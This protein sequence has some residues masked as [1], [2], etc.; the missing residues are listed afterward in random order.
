[1]KKYLFSLAAALSIFASSC[2]GD[3]GWTVEGNIAGADGQKMVVEGFNNGSWYTLDTL[4][5]KNGG[6]FEYTSPA[7]SP[8]PDIYRLNLD[9]KMIYFP[10][11]SIETVTVNGNAKSFDRDF[12][13]S[14]SELAT[15]L[16]NVDKKILSVI[17]QKGEKA[18]ATDS[19]LKR[20]LTDIVIGDTNGVIAYYII[21]KNIGG[22]ALFD[23]KDSRDIRII[24]AVAN[25]FDINRPNDPRTAY[26]KYLFLQ[27]R[28]RIASTDSSK[29]IQV[30]VSGLYDINLYDYT[31]KKHSLKDVASKG[32]VTI[33]SFVVYDAKESPAYNIKLNEIYKAYKAQGL[34]IYQVSI[35]PEETT[36]KESAKNLPWITVYNSP[37]D[38]ADIVMKYNVQAVPM[39][40]IINRQ[41]DL[42]ERV[43]D[44]NSLAKAVQK[45]M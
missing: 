12:E 21:N 25:N 23:V 30:E 40:Y 36:W 4:E 9:G 39:T 17:A 10:I 22:K 5:V 35:D 45:Y 28:P 3:N 15:S 26:L 1:M 20:E 2:N 44:V 11:D 16:M 33:L 14:G 8:N 19:I 31:G 32:N 13:L 24:G 41:G 34:E 29:A 7:G 37:V 43:T 18:A 38:G 27:N 6:K 42:A